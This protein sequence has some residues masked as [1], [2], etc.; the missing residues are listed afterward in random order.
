MGKNKTTIYIRGNKGL[1]TRSIQLPTIEQNVLPGKNKS[2]PSDIEAAWHAFISKGKI[3]AGALRPEIADSWK[4]CR[5]LGVDPYDGASPTVLSD[6]EFA[7][8]L[9]RKKNLITIAVPFMQRLYEVINDSGFAVVLTDEQGYILEI[10][11]TPD[12]EEAMMQT[13]V[14]YLP[15]SRWLEQDVGTNGIELVLRFKKPYQMSGAEHYAITHHP[16][17][18][19]GAPI[20]NAEGEITGTLTASGIAQATQKHTA[21]MMVAA[22]DVITD[23]IMLR[24]KNRQLTITN[25][26]LA[27]VLMSMSDGV[28]VTDHHGIIQQMNPVAQHMLGQS[29][30]VGYDTIADFYEDGSIYI[31]NVLGKGSPTL[32]KK[33]PYNQRISWPRPIPSRTSRIRSWA[34]SS[35]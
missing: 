5:A 3:K 27:N 16:V 2:K 11:R 7:A 33:S 32:I 12:L 19:I 28:I 1:S 22:V 29:I 26:R 35:S 20:F 6:R 8:L 30:R 25:N 13:H 15:G 23:E 9:S 4:R 31:E 34:E 14:N 24:E 17:A 18:C 21:A 10:V